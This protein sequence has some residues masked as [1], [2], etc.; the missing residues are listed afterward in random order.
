MAR[1]GW[2]KWENSLG[3]H[4]CRA[5]KTK[6]GRWG[7]RK[8]EL[9]LVALGVAQRNGIARGAR[10]KLILGQTPTSSIDYRVV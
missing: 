9:C 3:C 1:Q 2:A 6:N 8:V 7:A 4:H 5:I 10:Q